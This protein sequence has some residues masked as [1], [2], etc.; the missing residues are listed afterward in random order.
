MHPVV[1]TVLQRLGLGLVTLFVVSI[2]IFTT[3]EMLPGDFARA[4]LGQSATPATVAAFEK[5]VGLDRPPIQRYF[6]WL[7]GVLE[8]DFGNSFSALGALGGGSKRTVMSLVGP[9]LK[10]TLF[11]AGLTAIIAVPLALVLGMLAALYRNSLFDRVVNLVSLTSVS[12]PEFFIA[13]I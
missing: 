8:G 11:L 12:V 10:N 4:I 2:I 5:E 7:G 9:R 13:Y 1:R 6:E 3:V